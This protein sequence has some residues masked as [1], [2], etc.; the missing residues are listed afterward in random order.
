MVE[1]RTHKNAV[2][3]LADSQRIT[4]M[5]AQEL[6]QVIDNPIHIQT[7]EDGSQLRLVIQPDYFP[8]RPVDAPVCVELLLKDGTIIMGYEYGHP[9]SFTFSDGTSVEESWLFPV[10]KDEKT[11]DN[12]IT[13]EQY[14]MMVAADSMVAYSFFSLDMEERQGYSTEQLRDMTAKQL[15]TI[16]SELAPGIWE[17]RGEQTVS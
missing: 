7:L 9:G 5:Q 3:K 10:A 12:L 17:R 14:R 8:Y 11:A 16:V 15:H 1:N 2:R 4:Y 13:G 6:Q